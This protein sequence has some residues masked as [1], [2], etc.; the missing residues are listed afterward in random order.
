MKT[1]INVRAPSIISLYT[2]E[3][4]ILLPIQVSVVSKDKSRK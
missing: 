4:F 2:A 1:C 3:V